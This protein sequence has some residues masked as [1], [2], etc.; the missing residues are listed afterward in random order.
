MQ[1]PPLPGP[2]R[3]HFYLLVGRRG[4]HSRKS[5]HTGD[6]PHSLLTYAHPNA[7]P[8]TY[9][10]IHAPTPASAPSN[11]TPFPPHANK[12]QFSYHNAGVVT[13]VQWPTGPAEGGEMVTFFGINFHF[14]SQV[15]ERVK[16]EKRGRKERG[17]RTSTLREEET[18][19][20]LLNKIIILVAV[21]EPRD[22]RESWGL[23]RY[24]Y[25][26]NLTPLSRRTDSRGEE[27]QK[28]HSDRK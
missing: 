4:L 5:A 18:L 2:G 27:I 12:P 11:L 6:H 26:P 16:R 7:R 17:T 20:N 24:V 14:A 15:R 1:H 19:E 10:I 22:W 9:P 28:E 25:T 23:L 3:G 21:R 13:A 8:S